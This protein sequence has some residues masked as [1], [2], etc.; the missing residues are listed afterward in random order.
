M[1]S[2]I[3]HRLSAVLAINLFPLMVYC[4][5]AEGQELPELEN[6]LQG[7][8]QQ[9]PAENSAGDDNT[10]FSKQDSHS[11]LPADSFLSGL[12]S[13]DFFYSPKNHV[14]PAGYRIY[15]LRS[16]KTRLALTMESKL[17][18]N[19]FLKVNGWA[20]YDYAYRKKGLELFSAEV[21]DEY[22]KEFELGETYLRV[23]LTDSFDITFGRQIIIWGKSDF[24]RVTDLWNPNDT[25]EP[26]LSDFE[27][28]RLPLLMTKADGYLGPWRLSAIISHEYRHDK[29]VVFGNDFYPYDFPAPDYE[30]KNNGAENSSVGLATTRCYPGFDIGIYGGSFVKD[31]DIVGLKA[32]TPKRYSSRIAML[33]AAAEKATGHWLLK[34]EAALV[35]GLQYYSLA[36]EEK[37]RLDT[38]AGVDYTG[39]AN[40]R[41][42]FEMVN[43]HLFDYESEI[44]ERDDTPSKNSFIWTFRAGKSFLRDKLDLVFLS[45]NGGIDFSKGSAQKLSAKYRFSD[46]FQLS[47]GYLLVQSGDNYL[48]RNIGEND[49]FFLQLRYYL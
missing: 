10:S 47:T 29:T 31:L 45:Y 7:F 13:E 23:K 44:A 22:E 18:D 27:F 46:S 33:G 36:G 8:A 42:S 6:I 21:V 12:I 34:S 3:L 15:G 2:R 16:L 5:L 19:N 39:F 26:G 37:L 38:L 32:D 28:N 1:I 14:T 17:S 25:R 30:D 48:T 40:S 11:I 43:R 4:T 20:F 9:L 49:T 41:L 35:G 24:F